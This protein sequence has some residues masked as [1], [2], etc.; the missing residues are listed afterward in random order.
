MTPLL[1]QMSG[2]ATKVYMALRCYRNGGPSDA[3]FTVPL[4]RLAAATALTAHAVGTARRDLFALGLVR[5]TG[6]DTYMLVEVRRPW[7]PTGPI[8]A[9]PP[10]KA[11]Q[12][13]GQGAYSTPEVIALTEAG[14][15]AL[16]VKTTISSQFGVKVRRMVAQRLHEGHTREDLLGVLEWARQRRQRDNFA[17]LSNLV[18]LWGSCLAAHL[19]SQV[20]EGIA[21]SSMQF[22]AGEA[23]VQFDEDAAAA[24]ARPL[25]VLG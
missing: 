6:P 21:P 4:T 16:R 20:A 5:A 24:A 13:R 10:A 9:L 12:P 14:I 25:P 15:R 22:R 8:D 18:Y 2:N 1:P 17:P 7:V 11:T 3:A 23:K 19:A